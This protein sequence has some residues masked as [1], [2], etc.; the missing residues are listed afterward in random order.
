[1]RS[2][3]QA[4]ARLRRHR[5]KS[6]MTIATMITTTTNNIT[7]N[8]MIGVHILSIRPAEKT[9]MSHTAASAPETPM[10]GAAAA[11][12]VESHGSAR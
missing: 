11:G 12:G 4:V 10:L 5:A 7:N 3:N 6:Q 9:V 2:R 1:M 8:I